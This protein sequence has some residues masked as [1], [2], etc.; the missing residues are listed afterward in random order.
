M[1]EAAGVALTDADSELDELLADLASVVRAAVADQPG[2]QPA[3]APTGPDRAR[4]RRYA[5]LGWLSLLVDAERGGA[6][7]D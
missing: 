5:E 4:W 2:D 3:A 1:P 6:G 7:A